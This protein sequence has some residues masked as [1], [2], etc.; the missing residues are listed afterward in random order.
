MNDNDFQD[1]QEQEQQQEQQ[2]EQ[3]Q[4]G[5]T[6][7]DMLRDWLESEY[8]ENDFS[9]NAEMNNTGGY[10][11]NFDSSGPGKVGSDEVKRGEMKI[12]LDEV[13]GIG[14][15]P[16]IEL[17]RKY[18]IF[19]DVEVTRSDKTEN[20]LGLKFRGVDV[21]VWDKSARGFRFT[22]SEQGR[23]QEHLEEFRERLYKARVEYREQVDGMVDE[24]MAWDGFFEG[25]VG[26]TPQERVQDL[27]TIREQKEVVRLQTI[28]FVEETMAEMYPKILK[29]F[30]EELKV[31][32]RNGVDYSDHLRNLMR[33]ITKMDWFKDENVP[34]DVYDKEMDFMMSLRT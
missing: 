34:T 17:L 23:A 31:P 18:D 2:Q 33:S 21:V 30:E 11:F 19:D 28:N 25:S 16:S 27:N 26:E 4:E 24:E 32:D 14:T 20:F 8:G 22:T 15:T 1:A 9:N 13:E 29:M 10:N 5:A 6:D 3:E 7:F 12:I